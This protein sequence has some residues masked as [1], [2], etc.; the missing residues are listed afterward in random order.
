MSNVNVGYEGA[1]YQ[2]HLPERLPCKVDGFDSEDQVGRS[3]LPVLMNEYLRS[4][5]K[6]QIPDMDYPDVR[7]E[8]FAVCK[9]KNKIYIYIY[10]YT[11]DKIRNY[12]SIQINA[13]TISKETIKLEIN[14]NPLHAVRGG[15]GF[16]QQTNCRA[17]EQIPRLNFYL[18]Q[19]GMI[20]IVPACL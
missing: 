17:P 14:M 18:S 5:Y 3:K 8:H 12:V 7:N 1:V 10:I 4:E 9:K 6:V 11:Y 19:V 2:E 16:L 15:R 13:T 20:S